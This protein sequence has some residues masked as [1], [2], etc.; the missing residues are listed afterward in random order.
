LRYH[1]ACAEQLGTRLLECPPG[2]LNPCRSQFTRSS[3]ATET[4]QQK[5]LPDLRAT[6]PETQ[7]RLQQAL[8]ILGERGHVPDRVIHVQAHEPTEQQVVIEL[9]QFALSK[10]ENFLVPLAFFRNLLGC[11]LVDL[12]PFLSIPELIWKITMDQSIHGLPDPIAGAPNLERRRSVR[13]KLHTPVYASFNGPRT[14]MVVDL[15]ELLDLHE[16]G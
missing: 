4:L 7:P 8:T 13:Q 12:A 11:P 2:F 1:F 14:G 6:P 16:D 5:S 15:S 10:Q 3:R 9:F